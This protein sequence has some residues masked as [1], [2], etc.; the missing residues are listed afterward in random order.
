MFL[1]TSYSPQMNL[2]LMFRFAFCSLP[3]LD[4]DHD[5]NR[6]TRESPSELFRAIRES[7]QGN[8]LR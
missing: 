1:G 8:V 5:E 7:D 2:K 3:D 6:G 4:D